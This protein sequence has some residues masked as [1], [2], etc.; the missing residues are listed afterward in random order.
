MRCHSTHMK[1]VEASLVCVECGFDM[2]GH[3]F[4]ATLEYNDI[5][6]CKAAKMKVDAVR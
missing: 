4:N 3:A 6:H 2:G 1:H 5:A